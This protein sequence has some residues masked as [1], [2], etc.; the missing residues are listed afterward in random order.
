MHHGEWLEH[1]RSDRQGGAA[2]P[3]AARYGCC[4][5]GGWEGP[6]WC[7]RCARTRSPPRP[8][9][10]I[11]ARMA[12]NPM[13]VSNHET[14]GRAL[15][16]LREGL[17]PFLGHSEIT[18]RAGDLHQ[19]TDLVNATPAVCSDISDLCSSER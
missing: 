6:A 8:S 3:E 9:C 2:C 12:R 11:G 10:C 13:I 5:Q 15:R 16:L 17:R 1:R 14:V 19:A 7:P 18:I 4:G